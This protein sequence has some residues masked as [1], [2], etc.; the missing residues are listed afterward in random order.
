[1]LPLPN[2]SAD[3]EGRARV[4][5]DRPSTMC[6]MAD[7]ESTAPVAWTDLWDWSDPGGS[8]ER[9]REAAADTRGERRLV[10]LTQAARALGLQK[11]YDEGH[12]VLDGV[13]A[14]PDGTS[15]EVSA[16][17]ALERGRLLRSAGRETEAAPL[18]EHAA[19][20]AEAAGLEAL[21][22]DALHMLALLGD[23]PAEQLRRTQEALAV[24]RAATADDARRWDASLLNN[25]GMAQHDL[26]DLDAA[27]GSFQESLEL[28][29][30]RGQVAE[31]RVARW[32]VAWTLRLL[33][34]VDEAL[35]MQRA[36]RADL[37]AAGEKDSYVEEE[38]AILEA[39]DTA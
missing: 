32:M 4:T 18:F 3:L 2:S 17:C 38:L 7:D 23:D 25:L 37:D 19:T 21:H 31:S 34:R 11:R 10:A 6:G 35:A 29:E 28:R 16:R 12:D 20:E 36:L 22:V 27:L 14:D 8:E 9:F 5:A 1:M 15:P 39:S 33:G 13:A 30:R 24:A 26:G